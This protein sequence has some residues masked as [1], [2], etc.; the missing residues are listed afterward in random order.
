M[1]RTLG[2]SIA[3]IIYVSMLGYWGFF[4]SKGEMGHFYGLRVVVR[5]FAKLW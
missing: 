4:V 5:L 3:G 1:F 2:F